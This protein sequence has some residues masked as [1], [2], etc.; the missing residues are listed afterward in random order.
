MTRLGN[1]E[2]WTVKDWS[3]VIFTDE[4]TFSSQR[5]GSK[6]V[7]KFRGQPAQVFTFKGPRKVTVNCWGYITSTGVGKLYAFLMVL[8]ASS[9]ENFL[10]VFY[11]KS[12][13]SFLIAFLCKTM[14]LFIVLNL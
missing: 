1:Q 4:K 9:M 14:R 7:R 11:Q 8:M 6:R 12:L 5:T 2:N 3:R 10:K 13:K